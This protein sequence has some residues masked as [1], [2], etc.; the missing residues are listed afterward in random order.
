MQDRIS[1]ALKGKRKAAD[2]P[3]NETETRITRSRNRTNAGPA[4]EPQIP[5]CVT[6]SQLLQTDE[7]TG[8]PSSGIRNSSRSQP[9]RPRVTYLQGSE[10]STSKQISLRHPKSPIPNV[11]MKSIEIIDLTT[12][13]V[14]FNYSYLKPS[15]LF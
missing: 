10:T 3:F 12:E 8:E 15:V 1:T 14:S 7:V 2:L 4:T 5:N 6:L 13:Y 9:K 11:Y